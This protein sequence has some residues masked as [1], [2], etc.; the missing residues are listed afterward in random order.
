MKKD[1]GKERKV[2]TYSQELCNLKNILKREEDQF[3]RINLPASR[4]QQSLILFIVIQ[5]YTI[6]KTQVQSQILM[7]STIQIESLI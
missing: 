1:S 3:F 7:K 4:L 6:I 5:F 2:V